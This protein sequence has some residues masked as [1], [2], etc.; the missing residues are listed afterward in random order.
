MGDPYNPWPY[1]LACIAC[2]TGWWIT[3]A[4]WLGYAAML[5]LAIAFA[6]SIE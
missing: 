1:R 3:D 2:F 5:L 4:H 6:L